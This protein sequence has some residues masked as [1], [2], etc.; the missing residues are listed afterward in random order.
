MKKKILFLCEEIWSMGTNKGVSSLARLISSAQIEYDVIVFTPCLIK[1]NGENRWLKYF[2]SILNYVIVNIKYIINGSKLK[3][4]DIVYISSSLPTIAGFILKKYFKIK[5]I[6]R[7]YGTFLYS[8]MYSYID[9]LKS[10]Q[11]VLS[12]VIPADKYIITDDGTYGNIVAKRF[13]IEINKVLYL[14]NG[15]DRVENINREICRNKIRKLYGIHNNDII[16]LSVSRL[17]NWKR[18][19]RI[20]EAMN[21]IEKQNIYHIIVGDGEMMS[22]YMGMSKNKNI[23]FAGAQEGDIVKEYMLASDIF[24]SMYDLSN[25]GNPILEAMSAG[26]AVITLDVGN[27]SDIYDGTNMLMIRQKDETDIIDNLYKYILEL[28]DD[29]SLREI[30]QIKAQK[31]AKKNILSWQ[32]RINYELDIIKEL[33][34]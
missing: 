13:H 8:K 12:F 31:Y 16:I 11:E 32:E 26:L 9:L 23:I 10:H 3:D 21:M 20:I 22:A 25:L 2:N 7:I 24:V 19:D 1:Y 34:K 6:Q 14:K 29:H 28:A 17:V 33:S 30:L 4:I 5:S 18:V 15:V 27:T